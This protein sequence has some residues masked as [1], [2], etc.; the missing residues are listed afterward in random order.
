LGAALRIRPFNL[1]FRGVTNNEVDPSVDV[2]RTVTLSMIRR[3][4]IDDGL[5]LKIAKR[6]AAPL[7]GGEVVFKCPIVRRLNPINLVAAGKI[8]RI[9]GIAYSTRVSPQTANRVVDSARGMLNK[10]LPD[11]YIYTDHYRGIEAG[12]SPGFGLSLV[13]ETVNNVL[14][15]AD[16]VARPVTPRHSVNTVITR[17]IVR[18][19]ASGS[20]PL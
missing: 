1:K 12:N 2:I 14:I 5:E 8:K 4:G 17:H 7:G 11:V 15:S 18:S 6:G 19:L 20:A 10:C 13:A 16:C 9:R 3:F